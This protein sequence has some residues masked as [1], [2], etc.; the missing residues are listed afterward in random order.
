[1]IPRGLLVA[2]LC[3]SCAP[4]VAYV[5]EGDACIDCRGLAPLGYSFKDEAGVEL[6]DC[7]YYVCAPSGDQSY[8]LRR[9]G[10]V[11]AS[12]DLDGEEGTLRGVCAPDH[13]NSWGVRCVPV[14]G[15]P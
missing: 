9:E 6:T 8:S 11:G 14:G 13:D 7:T 2:L 15:Q 1:M 10:I 4:D 3:L 12:C 5:C